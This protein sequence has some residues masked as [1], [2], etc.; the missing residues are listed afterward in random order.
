[1]EVGCP[2]NNCSRHSKNLDGAA[3]FMQE[4]AVIHNDPPSGLPMVDKKLE[5]FNEWV[6][7]VFW[8]CEE[9]LS[10]VANN[11]TD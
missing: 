8:I 11:R 3:F 1:M 2:N 10:I 7:V 6:Q 5:G 9:C 4:L